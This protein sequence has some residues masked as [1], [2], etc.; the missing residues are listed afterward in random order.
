MAAGAFRVGLS[1]D[2]RAADGGPLFDALA[3]RWLHEAP[4]VEVALLDRPAGAPVERSDAER[5][6][7]L[8]IKRNRVDAGVVD[9]PARL[10]I[11]ARNGVGFDHVD[12]AACTRAGV[13]V[14]LTPRAVARPVA[15]ATFAL[16]LALAHRIVERDR[17]T[18]AGE[19]ARRLEYP[20]FGLTGR[21]LGVVGLGGIGCE[22]LRLAAPWQ[23]RHLGATPRPRPVRYAGL[24]VDIVPL[25][26]LLA[27]SDF[28]ALCCP[29]NDSTRGMIDARAL[30]RMPPHAVLVN[31]AR[32][33]IVDETA[34]VEALRAG[35]LAGAGL[36]VYAHEPPPPGHPLFALPN[37]ILGSHNLA[38]TD[39]LNA[40][41]NRGVARAVLDVAAGRVPEDLLDPAVLAH[42]RVRERAAAERP[43]GA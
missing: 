26:E 32:G 14:T 19:W 31:A 35:R 38:I 15:S 27:R 29:L 28:V 7:A 12:V 39:E 17:R 43:P 1:G 34:L 13:M 23:M 18:R 41:A 21:T 22:L 10:R 36:D 37:V 20:G 5:F 2:F 25:D 9:G 33:E 6:D 40:A 4:G 3:W 42:A 24:A 16:I 11:V 30:A 8:V